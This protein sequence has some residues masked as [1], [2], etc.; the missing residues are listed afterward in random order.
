MLLQKTWKLAATSQQ[1]NLK[2]YKVKIRFF[3][4]WNSK[5][6]QA[7]MDINPVQLSS[8]QEIYLESTMLNF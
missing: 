8:D 4:V 2:F 7:K 5:Q 1:A 6:D 3:L